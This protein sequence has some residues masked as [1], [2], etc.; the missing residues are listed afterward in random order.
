MTDHDETQLPAP[1]RETLIATGKQKLGT[2]HQIREWTGYSVKTLRKYLQQLRQME[3]VVNTTAS[4]WKLS[5]K[6]ERYFQRIQS[7]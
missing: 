4:L 7:Q 6:G 1:L 5:E 2:V 3:L